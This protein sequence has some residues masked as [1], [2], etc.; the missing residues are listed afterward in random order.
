MDIVDDAEGVAAED[1]VVGAAVSLAEHPAR[2]K[3]ATAGM[4]DHHLLG[5]ERLASLG[6]P[7]S[8]FMLIPPG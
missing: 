6:S 2:T 1:F 4:D 7:R 3:A 8:K 5:R